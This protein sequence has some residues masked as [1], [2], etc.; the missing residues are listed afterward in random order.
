MTGHIKK[1]VFEQTLQNLGFNQTEIEN[2]LAIVYNPTVPA[3]LNRAVFWGLKKFGRR[4]PLSP[5]AITT[6]MVYDHV[7]EFQ[8]VARLAKAV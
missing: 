8:A 3:I 7:N 1:D 5:G 6:I 4:A 2:T